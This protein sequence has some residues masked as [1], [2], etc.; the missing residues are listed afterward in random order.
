MNDFD[1]ASPID[2]TDSTLIKAFYSNPTDL[3]SRATG[4][5]FVVTIFPI[6][7][8]FRL[9]CNVL[10]GL[11]GSEIQPPTNGSILTYIITK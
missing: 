4:E 2:I 9:N 10:A 7:N 6:I 1:I 8:H 11:Q 5:C 3:S